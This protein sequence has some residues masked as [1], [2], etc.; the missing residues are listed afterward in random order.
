V[1][2]ETIFLQRFER[3]EVEAAVDC[4]ELTIKR[5]E[6]A[7]RQMFLEGQMKQR[8]QLPAQHLWVA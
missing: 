2:A 6:I 7:V 8:R 5:N 4:A 1:V 3:L